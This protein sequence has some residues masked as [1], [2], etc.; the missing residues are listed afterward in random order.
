MTCRAGRLNPAERGKKMKK[1]TQRQ[2]SDLSYQLTVACL[3]A[4][5]H[6]KLAAEADDA[7]NEDESDSHYADFHETCNTIASLLVTLTAGQ[8][9]ELTA[10]RM[11]YH[12]REQIQALYR[13]HTA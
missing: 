4:D 3:A 2:I 11:A 12:K 7:G 5:L 8:I 13:K 9:D 10:R 6:Y 1:L